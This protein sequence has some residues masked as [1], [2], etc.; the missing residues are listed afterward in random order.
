MFLGESGDQTHTIIL[1]KATIVAYLQ[2]IVCIGKDLSLG[3]FF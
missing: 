2:E 1:D 3:S